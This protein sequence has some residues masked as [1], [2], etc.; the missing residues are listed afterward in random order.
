MVIKTVGVTLCSVLA[1]SFAGV[2]TQQC[3]G[4]CGTGTVCDKGQCVVEPVKAEP[5]LCVN[6]E[7][8]APRDLSTGAQ[9]SKHAKAA[10]LTEEQSDRM[11]QTNIHFHF[12]AEHK[13]DHYNDSTDSE[14]FD[15]AHADDHHRRLAGAV[16]PGFMCSNE[17]LTEEQLKPYD[18]QH[19]QGEMHVGKT[20]EVHYV[21]STAGTADSLDDG[22]G[23]AAG[24]RGLANPMV[25]VNAQIFQIVNDVGVHDDSDLVHGWD[26]TDHDEAVMYAGSTTGTSVDN[27]VCSP[28][29]VSWHV[30]LK[31]HLISAASFDNMCKDMKE[32]Y[33]MENDLYPHG[34]RILLD[35]QFV[36][37]ADEVYPLA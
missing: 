26:H 19:C 34:S 35:E 4:M 33:N 21:H 36:V 15:D 30:D 8:Q 7:V 10:V 5:L 2:A 6:A 3:A 31:C 28:Y 23:T 22:L 24:G 27:T 25:T 37:P 11:Y 13:S 18:W 12:G 29:A 17:G 14:A 1:A 20:Y 16:R 9:G 32:L